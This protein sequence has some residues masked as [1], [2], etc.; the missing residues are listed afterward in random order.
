MKQELVPFLKKSEPYGKLAI[1]VFENKYYCFYA[2]NEKMDLHE[3]LRKKYDKMKQIE[4]KPKRN[5]D[6][7][8]IEKK[9]EDHQMEIE[10]DAQKTHKDFDANPQKENS[11]NENPQIQIEVKNE[12]IM[13]QSDDEE[14]NQ[15]NAFKENLIEKYRDEEHKSPKSLDL[16]PSM[17]LKPSVVSKPKE[18]KQKCFHCDKLNH[19]KPLFIIRRCH[20]TICFECMI[21]KYYQLNEIKDSHSCPA[22]R[23][24]CKF[25]LSDIQSYFQEIQIL[26]S[27][28]NA[29]NI[30]SEGEKLN[31]NQK[32]EKIQK[33]EK[34]NGK[35][36]NHQ[37]V[38]N[39]QKVEKNENR[40]NEKPE[41]AQ[42]PFSNEKIEKSGKLL[43]EK[44]EKSEKQ[45]KSD[46]K[47]GE[48]SKNENEEK[49]RKIEE[50]R[51]AEMNSEPLKMEE[52]NLPDPNLREKPNKLEATS[53]KSLKTGNEKNEEI[54]LEEEKSYKNEDKSAKKQEKD[55]IMGNLFP[56]PKKGPKSSPKVELSDKNIDPIREKDAMLIESPETESI[57]NNLNIEP[58][59]ICVSCQKSTPQSQVFSNP[60]CGHCYCYECVLKLFQKNKEY[61][62]CLSKSCIKLIKK[63]F[64]EKYLEE[65][66]RNLLENDPGKSKLILQICYNCQKE[67]QIHINQNSEMEFFQCRFCLK[68]S[69]LIHKAS[70]TNCFCFCENCA[71]KTTPDLIRPTRKICVNCRKKYCILCRNPLVKC[72]CYCNV[73]EEIIKENVENEGIA[74][75]IEG[76]KKEKCEKCKNCELAC[77]KCGITLKV[78]KMVTNEKCGHLFCRECM[79]EFIDR[80]RKTQCIFEHSYY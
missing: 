31:E 80:F 47:K 51:P 50:E 71:I 11:Q 13:I 41:K 19:T 10:K 25:C 24:P 5:S 16:Q 29:M 3:E 4:K 53:D 55:L 27:Q 60:L 77:I 52:E 49:S 61:Y 21:D 28:S 48:A 78:E 7:M 64:I 72:G 45:E 40:S 63:T 39:N 59:I 34:I 32:K 74:E 46:Q 26:E 20:H 62:Y 8:E 14:N 57:Q 12:V 37:K 36:E 6:T 68:S 35:L 18:I 54:E 33:V 76:K 69:C 2:I 44:I 67:S 23:C 66:N 38:E 43:N 73:C 42:K 1:V 15:I 22:I 65:Y 79:Y 75:K 56:S 30:E 58:T 70:L 9:E 17:D